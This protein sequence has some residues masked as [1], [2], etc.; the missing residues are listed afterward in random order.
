MKSKPIRMGG[1]PM[2]RNA[3]QCGMRVKTKQEVP[4]MI[5]KIPPTNTHFQAMS[6]MAITIYVGT[7]WIKKPTIASGNG[8]PSPNESRANMLIKNTKSIPGILG[9]H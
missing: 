9:S 2:R 7:R 8:I 3:V 6:K 4:A 5:N 1:P